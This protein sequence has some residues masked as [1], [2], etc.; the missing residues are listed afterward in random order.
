MAG[1]YTSVA[2]IAGNPSP[3]GLLGG[4]VD[5]VQAADLHE[6]NG[7]QFQ[8]LSCATAHPW[9]ANCPPPTTPNPAAKTFDRP[10]VC[11]F[12]PVTVYGG[13]ECS[14]I[15]D[16]HEEAV[17]RAREQ[18]R[19]GEQRALEEW[20]MSNALCQMAQGNDLTPASGALSV[21]QAVAALEGWLAETYGGEGLL[22]VPAA[23]AALLGC[24]NVVTRTRDTQCPETLMGNGV[25]FG[26][27]YAANVGGTGCTEA[28]AGEAWLY[29]T[30]PVRVRQDAVQVYPPTEAGSIDTRLNDRRVLA[31]R[32]SVIEVACC[33]AAMVRVDLCC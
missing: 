33:T 26:S 4:C 1:Y 12:D 10:G 21:Q 18:L 32:T 29:I 25:I 14:A 30:P 31:E 22:H 7:T 2:P 19:M 6:L 3:Y 28:P 8:P 16:T 11:E 23:A 17:A 20:F 5:V 15:S 9:Q 27:G 24:C 13:Y